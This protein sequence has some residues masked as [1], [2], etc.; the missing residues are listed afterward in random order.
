MAACSRRVQ[1]DIGKSYLFGS[2]ELGLVLLEILVQLDLGQLD[3]SDHIGRCKGDILE[4]DPVI[5]LLELGQGVFVCDRGLVLDRLADLFEGQLHLLSILKILGSHAVALQELLV[6]VKTE[7]A[8]LLEGGHCS[9]CGRNLILGDLDVHRLG[10]LH[11]QA[12]VD[13]GVQGHLFQSQH[14]LHLSRQGLA[15]DLLVYVT[16]AL[17]RVLIFLQGNPFAVDLGRVAETSATHAAAPLAPHQKHG[18]DKRQDDYNKDYFDD[19]RVLLLAHD[20]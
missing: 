19:D 5:F 17:I 15:V 9:Y 11:D 7:G 3:L 4:I 10:F 14:L 8:V 16:D 12:V 13:Q 18:P 2:L 20:I 1:Q 6:E